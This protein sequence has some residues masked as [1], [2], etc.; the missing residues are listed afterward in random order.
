[1]RAFL[2]VISVSLIFWCSVAIAQ[3]P[4]FST[5][6]IEGETEGEFNKISLFES[7]SSKEPFKTSYISHNGEYSIDVDIP[8]DMRKKN[9]YLFVDMRFWG[10]KNDNDI[11]DP[12]E[13]ISKCHFI[14]WVPSD[15]IVYM[16]VYEGPKFPFKH[17]I[18]NYHYENE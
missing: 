13:P 7:G 12:G 18:L 3:S 8:D 9:S 16:Q 11:K 4:P 10:D 15:H 2:L 14:I 6:T 5:V 1:M 17:S